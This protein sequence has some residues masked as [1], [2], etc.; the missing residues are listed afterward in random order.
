MR[1]LGIVPYA[2][3]LE[4]QHM[5]RDR[6]L[7]GGDD[8]LLLLEH[9]AVV[10]LGKRGGVVDQAALDRLGIPVV[11]VDRGGQATWHG[12]GQLVGYPILDLRRR[13]LAIPSLIARLGA[14]LQRVACALGV[15]HAAFE[16]SRPGIYDKGRKLGAIGLHIQ[17]GVTTHGFALNVDCTLAGFDAI[18]ACGMP[19]LESTSVALAAGRS[20]T[21][22]DAKR[23]LVAELEL[24]WK[25]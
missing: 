18:E 4:I 5:A 24:A 22:D 20:V 16:P 14:L 3:G 12:P 23:A 15:D 6:V 8:E 9:D 21:V 25:G 19:G 17:R 2:T 13:G 10:T 1:D 7:A 11:A